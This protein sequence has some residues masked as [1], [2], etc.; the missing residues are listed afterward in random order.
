MPRLLGLRYKLLW[1]VRRAQ[2]SDIPKLK[3]Q[4]L[5]CLGLNNHGSILGFCCCCCCDMFNKNV[6]LKLVTPDFLLRTIDRNKIWQKQLKIFLLLLH[7][8]YHLLALAHFN[9]FSFL[10]SISLCK[11]DFCSSFPPSSGETI[12]NTLL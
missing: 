9:D 2:A 8:V 7:F 3:H 1:L 11:K 4:E 12:E 10:A 6:Y 5:I